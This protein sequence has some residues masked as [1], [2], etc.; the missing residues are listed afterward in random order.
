MDFSEPEHIQMLR[1]TVRRFVDGE[2]PR[3]QA[4]AWD[5]QNHFPRDVFDKLAELG[6]MGLTT[7]EE[8]GGSGRDIL[9]TMVVIEELARR[10]LAM[11][12]P[13]IMC[14][15][16]AG[17]NL[18]ECGSEEQKRTLLSR[19]AT[20]KLLFAYGWTEPDVGAD[21]ASVKTTVR[22]EG[23]ELVVNG[24]KR[25]CSGAD[26]CDYIYT[27]ARSGP[28]N[29]RYKNLSFVLVPPMVKGIT[30]ERI[31]SMGSKGAATTD[32][33]FTDVR[34][35]LENLVGGSQGWNRGWEMITG[36]GLDVEKLEVAALALGIAS[37]AFEDA[38]AYSQQRKQFGKAISEYQSIK[39]KLAD[40]RTQLHAARLMLNQAAWMSD[41][42]L[43]CGVET[44]MA[45]LFVTE[46]AKSIVL[47]CQT[48]LGA[49]G[50]VKE[51]DVERYVR[52][53][54]LMPIIGGS[55][56][57]QRNNIAKWSKLG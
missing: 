35:P 11:A 26:I 6:V 41:S 24:A 18:L 2:M 27:L 22:R 32:V 53:V 48:I 3:E 8:Y 42:G 51:V 30:I 12:V 43:R 34:V 52:D 33:I 9:G 44:S 21:L 36:A 38:C 15:C 29:D 19:V 49:Y 4:R 5:K 14:A 47:E 54:L 40:M 45:K 39:H 23:A 10:S 13:Y 50:Y 28:A 55:S 16:Y 1:E 25:F 46:A 57:I 17:M 20:G 7:P 37:A 56:A 31:E